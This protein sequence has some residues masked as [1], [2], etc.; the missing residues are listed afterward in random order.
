MERQEI[1]EW[2]YRLHAYYNAHDAAGIRSMLAPG[3]VT[4]GTSYPGGALDGEAYMSMW[5][6]MWAAFPD[7]HY[8]IQAMYIDGDTTIIRV[9]LIGT[10][11]G[12]YQGMP[13]T[14][15]MVRNEVMDMI[16]FADGQA[17]EE[18]TEYNALS[19]MQQLGLAP[20]QV[21]A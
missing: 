10:Q 5:S 12:E 21:A 9:S 4:H 7:L 13:A 11:V 1:K 18:W 2:S 20:A 17:Q 8:D 15:R 6:E 14:G 3:F 16:R 19:M